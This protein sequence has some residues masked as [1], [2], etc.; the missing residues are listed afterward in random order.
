MS[1][2]DR[3]MRIAELARRARLSAAALRYYE[4]E[5]L[6]RPS[7]RSDAGY[8]LYDEHAF[9]RVG[10]IRRAKALGL[11]LREIHR[12]TQE[13]L[14][15]AA[16]QARLRH[17]LV[18]KLADTQRRMSELATLRSELQAQLARLETTTT[19]CGCPDPNC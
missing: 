9:Q 8:G 16:E 4:R 15:G 13:P 14:A 17:A 7:G 12:L 19:C 2:G 10:F 11:T 1:V 6:L 5:G 18:Q 3:R